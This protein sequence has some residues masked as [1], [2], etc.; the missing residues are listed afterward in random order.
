MMLFNA[1]F[2]ECIEHYNIKHKVYKVITDNGSNIKKA[3]KNLSELLSVD[4]D[5]EYETCDDSADESFE[6]SSTS[7]ASSISSSASS[8]NTCNQE[9]PIAGITPFDY[10]KLSD[11]VEKVVCVERISCAGHNLQLAINDSLEKKYLKTLINKVSKL[12]SKSKSVKIQS[13]FSNTELY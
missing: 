11:E 13:Y 4:D 10:E 1:K 2:N 12:I 6:E 7:S 9:A 8:L 3:F 5:C